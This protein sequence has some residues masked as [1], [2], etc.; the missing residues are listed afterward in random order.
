MGKQKVN[1]KD[2]LENAVIAIRNSV[3]PQKIYLFG[4]HADNTYTDESDLDLCIVTSLQGLRKIDVLR[5]I[6]KAMVHDVDMPIDL[7]VYDD[8]DFNERSMLTTTM[9]HKIAQ[10]GVLLYVYEAI[11]HESINGREK[12]ASKC[13]RSLSWCRSTENLRQSY[14]FFTDIK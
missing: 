3:N 7:L 2:S 14:Y 6:R 10:E 8:D 12:P 13:S 1:A 4:S 11:A 9:E 5:K